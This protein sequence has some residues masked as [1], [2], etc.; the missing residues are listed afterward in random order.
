MKKQN[1]E[2]KI[3]NF[4]ERHVCVS[5]SVYSRDFAFFQKRKDFPN[6]KSVQMWDF[7]FMGGF[8]IIKIPFS[9]SVISFFF[10]PKLGMHFS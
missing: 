5:V 6:F 8:R 1:E 10:S 3:D 9:F 4:S 2:E 7:G